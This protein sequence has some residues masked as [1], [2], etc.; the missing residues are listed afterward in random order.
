M[1]QPVSM[2]LVQNEAWAY[3]FKNDL[4]AAEK[5]LHAAE[6]KYPTDE[7]PFSTLTEIYFRIGH[8]T[9]AVALLESEL[10]RSP[11]HLGALVNLAAVKIQN[12]EYEAAIPLLDRALKIEP[13]NGY[14]L[15]NRAI[16]H[17]HSGRLDDSRRDYDALSRK[18]VSIPH[19]VHYGLAEIA[20]RQKQ[21]KAALK[22]YEEYLKV[23]PPDTAE[24]REVQQR[25]KRLKTGSI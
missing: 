4:A 7:T 14:A 15:I 8:T 18:M 5:V 1:P 21:V 23:A 17:L 24:H 11:G 20:W 6:Q 3:V 13:D 25:I 12:K 9:N 10:R 19:Q 22:H 2:A 16:A